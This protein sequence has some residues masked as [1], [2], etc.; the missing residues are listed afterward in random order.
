MMDDGD[1]SSGEAPAT[2]SGD[3]PATESA[4]RTVGVSAALSS[5]TALSPH[6]AEPTADTPP[7]EGRDFVLLHS[8][9][10]NGVRVLRSRNGT[11][12]VG[13]IRELK[14]GQPIQG[15]VVRLAPTDHERLYEVDVLVESPRRPARSGPAQVASAAYRAHWEAIFGA[16]DESLN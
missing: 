16:D 10:E 8:R 1:A 3:G 4:D 5:A 15:D 12:E 6:T 14:E 11:L 13:E 9:S 7:H 2:T